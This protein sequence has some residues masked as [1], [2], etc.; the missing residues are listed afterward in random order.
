[1]KIYVIVE[2]ANGKWVPAVGG[3]SSTTGHIRAYDNMTSAKRALTSLRGRRGQ[4]DF[5][6][7]RRIAEFSEVKEES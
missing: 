1:M 6:G 4:Q 2:K 5:D 3:G 7:P